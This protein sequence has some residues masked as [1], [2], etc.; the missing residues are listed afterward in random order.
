MNL[1]LPVSQVN[2]LD[3]IWLNGLQQ[4]QERLRCSDCVCRIRHLDSETRSPN[5]YAGSK[6]TEFGQMKLGR[7]IDLNSEKETS[8]IQKE[9]KGAGSRER[10]LVS[11][12]L[13]TQTCASGHFLP[14]GP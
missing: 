9:V 4:D 8:C 5:N 2:I 7:V 10:Q 11:L 6:L 3:S 12:M 1:L 14:M 13:K